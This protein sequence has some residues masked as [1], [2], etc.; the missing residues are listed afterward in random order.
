[1]SLVVAGMAISSYAQEIV[2]EEF[3]L[4]AKKYCV[5][6]NR[7]GANWFIAVN[8]GIN[9]YNGVF[10]NG[11]S[12]FEHISPNL[13]VHF[14][15]W[16]TPGLGWRAGYTGLN[17]KPWKDGEHTALAI[18]KFDIMLDIINMCCGYR[19]DRIYN[20]I[21][22]AGFGW[23]GRKAYSYENFEDLTGTLAISYGLLN[24]FRVA[25]RWSVNLELSGFAF[26]NGFCGKAGSSG[27]DMM[28]AASVGVTYRLGKPDWEPAVDITALQV[29]YGSAIAGL[30]S[31]LGNMS[32]QN[33]KAQSEIV[34]LKNQLLSVN[35][36][37]TKL[38]D[39]QNIIDFS[40]SAFFP[41][42]SAI[43]DSKKEELNIKAYAEAAKAAGVKL[44]VIGYA[45]VT[46][47]EQYNKTLSLQRAETVADILRANGADVETVTGQGESN[48]YSIKYLNRRAVIEVVK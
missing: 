12:P 19:K 24:T 37:Y 42:G 33:Q 6:T 8:G 17:M 22:Y 23:G 47:P 25:E 41:F 39:R 29:V 26:R 36:K 11:E 7:F 38:D 16:H 30:E 28:W 5:E 34:S 35:E 4:P 9:L 45:D 32:M 3:V 20:I 18:F 27:S 10:T 15:K 46:G 13:N 31:E 43:L 1:M 40:Q 44:R 14:G 2:V 21:P 48:D